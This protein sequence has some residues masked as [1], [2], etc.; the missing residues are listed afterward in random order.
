VKNG[1]LGTVTGV[2]DG[3][4]AARLDGNGRDGAERLVSVPVADYAAIDHG[5]ATTIH[6]TQGAT[7]DRAFVLASGTMDRHLT[8]VAMTRHRDGARLYADGQEFRG[9]MAALSARLSRDGSKETT[10]DYAQGFSERRGIAERLGVR[11]EIE[12]PARGAEREDRGQARGR[13]GETLDP[14]EAAAAEKPAKKRGMF[15]G[16]KLDSGRA[17]AG[18]G[19]APAVETERGRLLQATEAYARALADAARMRD[20]G[21]PIV[22]HQKVALE[23]SGAAL[24]AVWPGSTRELRSALRHDAETRQALTEA[25]GPER[26]ARLLAGMERERAA[27]RDPNVRAAR[28]VG[29]WNGLEAEHAK[30]RGFEHMEAREKIEG[31]MR[32]VAEAIGRDTQVESALRQNQKAFGI[33]AD[34]ALGRAIRQEQVGQALEHSLERGFRQRGQGMER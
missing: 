20:F 7:V 14:A 22:E 31:R 10:L 18:R 16:L 3:R 23:K 11:S 5:Y 34:S 32:A 33:G 13:E 26:A 1:M 27:Q 15:A 24:D 17:L 28:L 12:A 6:K 21:L 29:Q 4:I 19:A 8:Y 9:G 30:L 25:K 2:E